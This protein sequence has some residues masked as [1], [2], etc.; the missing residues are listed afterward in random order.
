MKIIPYLYFP[1]NAE[2]ALNFYRSVFG[3]EVPMLSRF[4]DGPDDMP[5]SPGMEDKLM[6]ARLQFGDATIYFSDGQEVASESTHSLT[7]EFNDRETLE[8]VYTGLSEGGTVHFELQDT[9]WGARY[10]KVTDK[11]GIKWDLNLQMA[12]VQS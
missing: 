3:G 6:H 10:G 8:S 4:S 11:F 12:V 1:G 7:V 5:V 9:F 2:E